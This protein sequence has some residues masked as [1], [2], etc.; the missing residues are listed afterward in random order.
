VGAEEA[1]LRQMVRI[2]CSVA[3]VVQMA[4]GMAKEVAAWATPR[5]WLPP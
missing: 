1:A 4:V 2:R 3:L 5:R